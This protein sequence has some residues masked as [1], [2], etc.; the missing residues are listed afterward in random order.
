M[1][2]TPSAPNPTPP[3][4]P[5][6]HECRKI[7]KR[8]GIYHGQELAE[9]FRYLRTPPNLFEGF[10]EPCSV[11]LLVG[12]S[13]IGKSV[14]AY[15]LA[16][17]VATGRPF[18]GQKTRKGKVVIVD[19]ENSLRASDRMVRQQTRH[20][21]LERDPYTLQVWPVNQPAH[22]ASRDA[23]MEVGQHENVEASIY[24][25]APDLAI[26]DS[27]RSF[28]PA[29]ENDNTAAVKQIQR[30]RTIAR[31]HGTA[32]LLVHHLRK[33]AR[34]AACFL[35]DAAPLDWMTRGAGSRA[36]INQTDARLAIAARRNG[37]A[38]VIRG[39]IRVQGEVGPYLISRAFDESGEPL[40]F[41][42]IEA[43]TEMLDNP[44]QEAVFHLLPE[45]FSFTEALKLYGRQN[46]ATSYFLQK[47]VRLGLVRKT[48][49]GQYRKNIF[50]KPPAPEAQ[51]DVASAA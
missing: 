20:L 43:S 50:S 41:E 29:M 1:E 14:L 26:F 30:L 39:H 23:L 28:N 45:A 42:R 18:L 12:E 46:Q 8:L 5:A 2:T 11:N 10:L 13:G 35:E 21:G 34:N 6:A 25:L 36:L 19:Y 38:L 3:L 31:L 40:G 9:R 24:Q 37:D 49:P 44:A 15:Q 17:A 48:A 51:V 22:K 4:D 27:L 7:K 16:M 33:Q 32:I 47:M